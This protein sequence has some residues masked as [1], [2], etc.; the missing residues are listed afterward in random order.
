LFQF[1]SNTSKDSTYTQP[2]ESDP[3]VVVFNF[4]QFS[5]PVFDMKIAYNLKTAGQIF[6]CI[7]VIVLQVEQKWAS[8]I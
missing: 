2:S 7:F 4:I 3:V 1:I 5:L 6:F 8:R